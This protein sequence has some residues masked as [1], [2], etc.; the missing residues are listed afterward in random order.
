MG[1]HNADGNPLPVRIHHGCVQPE[2]NVKSPR[3]YVQDTFPFVP[4]NNNVTFF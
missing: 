2:M 4:I 3:Y 1:T